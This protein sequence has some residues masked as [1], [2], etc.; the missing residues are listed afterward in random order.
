M[1]PKGEAEIG[2]N[3]GTGDFLLGGSASKC[4]DFSGEGILICEIST[5]FGRE[6]EAPEA[7]GVEGVSAGNAGKEVSRPPNDEGANIRSKRGR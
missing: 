1:T 7:D 4:L 2:E 3:T 5:E 6:N